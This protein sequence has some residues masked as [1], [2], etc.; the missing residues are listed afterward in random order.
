[1]VVLVTGEAMH[2]GRQAAAFM[3]AD[4][5]KV[6]I[7]RLSPTLSRVPFKGWGTMVT[8]PHLH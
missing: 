4:A 8:R 1:V 3:V 5:G 2:A 7:L 6:P